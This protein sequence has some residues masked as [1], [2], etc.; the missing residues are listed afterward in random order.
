MQVPADL[1]QPWRAPYTDEF[2]VDS[3]A[4]YSEDL[5]IS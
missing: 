5:L 3:S 4:G 1:S 2:L